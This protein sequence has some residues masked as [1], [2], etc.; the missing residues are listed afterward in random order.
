M[1]DDKKNLPSEESDIETDD[2]STEL[3]YNENEDLDE[4]DLPQIEDTEDSDLIIGEDDNEKDLPI[5]NLSSLENESIS[6]KEKSLF[7]KGNLIFISIKSQLTPGKSDVELSPILQQKMNQ[8]LKLWT[9]SANL[10]YS[11]AYYNLGLMYQ[12]GKGVEKNYK[13]ALSYFENAIKLGNTSSYY[14]IGLMY[15]DG[16]SNLEKNDIKA[17]ENFEKSNNSKALNIAG[18]MYSKGEGVERDLIKAKE[19]WEKAA[20]LD[21][22]DA[23]YNL[24]LL[25]ENDSN[26]DLEFKSSISNI[27][28]SL[29][30]TTSTTPITDITQSLN[31]ESDDEDDE[32]YT[33]IDEDI[34]KAYKKNHHP[35]EEELT[36]EQIMSRC[37]IVRDNNNN[38]IDPLHKTLPVLTKY[39]YAKIIGLRSAQIESG[40]AP[41]IPLESSIIDGYLIAE[42]EIRNKKL[43]YIIRRPL[44]G[45]GS[46]YWKLE[47]LEIL[48]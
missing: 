22:E 3:E 23:R 9:E 46:E 24:K 30:K 13:K 18:I 42:M 28:K 32:E 1:D 26:T 40:A 41:L 19:N 2:E 15:Y 10:G 33:K 5:I 4:N 17:L 36:N 38:I 7:E 12:Y 20:D 16:D 29:E 31:M 6:T 21:N 45:G 8:I 25:S 48:I 11:E 44:P 39:E 47:D 43:P 27:Q 14:Q 34:L 35:E 37:G